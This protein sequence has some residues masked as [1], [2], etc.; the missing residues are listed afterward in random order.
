MRSTSASSSR[1]HGSLSCP[2][3]PLLTVADLAS[4]AIISLLLSQHPATS[5]DPL[6]GEEDSD[7]LRLDSPDAALLRERVVGLVTE[8]MEEDGRE[9]GDGKEWEETLLV[10]S[11]GSQLSGKMDQRDASAVI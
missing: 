2:P 3:S 5:S 8:T 11:M 6:V 7:D 1:T 9:A 10:P 4:Q